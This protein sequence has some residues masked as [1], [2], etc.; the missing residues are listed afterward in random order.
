[1]SQS[2][3]T[4]LLLG[5][6]GTG[7]ELFARAVHLASGRHDQP[8]IKVNC[9]AIPETLFESELFGYERGA[10]TGA[11]T[12]R[13]GWFEQANGGSIFLDEIGELPL[14]MQSKLL[15]TLQEGTLVRL[16]GTREV[17]V[18]VRLVAATNRDL[19]KEVQAGRFRQDLYYRLNVIP[20]R[21][22]S[23]RERGE[24]VRALALHFVNRA[25]QAHQRNV[26]LAPDALARLEAHDWPGNIRELG[27]LIERLV[28]LADH[29]LVTAA[30]L[31]RFM[32]EATGAAPPSLTRAPD[33]TGDSEPLVRGYQSAQ[34]HSAQTLQQALAWHQGNQS[35]AAQSLGLTLRQFAYRLRKAGLR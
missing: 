9:S 5:E 31:E 20:I 2:Q 14:A 22:P 33:T 25:N 16:G 3:A 26:N 6:S 35:R 23:L 8:F 24:D 17:K 11:S 27:N 29:T 30:T 4:V 12:A 28:L 13:A 32:P 7:K 15:R 1:V 10:F 34:S 21:L 18:N 19:A